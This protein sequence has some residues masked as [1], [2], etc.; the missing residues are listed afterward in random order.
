M[1]LSSIGNFL[2]TNSGSIGSLLGT[3]AQLYGQQNA[4]EAI[5]SA[6]TSGIGQAQTYLGNVNN[7]YGA[8]TSLGNGAM[9]ALGSALGTNGQP[10][11]YSN[12][13]NMPG[14]QFAVQ[15]GTQAIQRQAASMGNAYTP[16]TAQAV[17]QYVTGTAMQDYNTYISQLQSAAGLGASANQTLAGANLQ[18][19][20]NIEQ[21]GM[22]SGMAQAGIYTGM[23]Q[24]LGGA[25][26]G[27]GSPNGSG[28]SSLIGSGLNFLGSALG[29]SGSSSSVYNSLGGSNPFSGA[30]LSAYDSS[31]MS[32]ISGPNAS[33]SVPDFLNGGTSDYGEDTSGSNLGYDSTGS[34][35]G[36]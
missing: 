32:D 1:D 27:T 21:L 22:N 35:S 23:G 2:S 12:F 10:A 15:Q 17:G 20:G 5:S 25:V 9:T 6:A 24:T 33:G 4:G 26:S 7:L 8:Q 14:Y 36:F 13:L 18:T 29:G 30:N 16:N 31:D 3:G 19:A 11:N 34:L 28:L